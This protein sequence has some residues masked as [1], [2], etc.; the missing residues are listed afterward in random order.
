MKNKIVV[1]SLVLLLLMNIML[2]ITA[3][4]ATSINGY[5]SSYEDAF[6]VN[7]ISS[8][9]EVVIIDEDEDRMIIGDPISQGCVLNADN[10]TK[11]I[12]PDSVI[13]IGN[14]AFEDCTRLSDV[15][16]SNSLKSIG[17][18]A[19]AGTGLTAIDLPDSL[20]SIDEGAFRATKITNVTVPGS[21]GKLVDGRAANERFAAGVFA[22]CKFLQSVT[23]QQG[24]SKVGDF[25]FYGCLS[26][27]S[28]SFANSV[29]TIGNEAFSGCRSLSSLSLPSGLKTLEGKAFAL[30]TSLT[31]VALPASITNYEAPVFYGCSDLEEIQVDALNPIFESVDGVLFSE[32]L[33]T[34]VEY[35]VGAGDEYV[36]PMGTMKIG[37]NAFYGCESLQSIVIPSSVK[38][39]GQGA[40]K[41]CDA[42]DTIYYGGTKAQW[43]ALSSNFASNVDVIFLNE[44]SFSSHVNKVTVPYGT[45]ASITANAK[46]SDL[47]YQWY[48]LEEDELVC[49][50]NGEKYQGV[51]TK[52]LVLDREFNI[53]EN[54]GKE[55]YVCVI[56]NIFGQVI[57][58]PSSVSVIHVDSD[59]KYD[60][61]TD[62]HWYVC[63][64]GADFSSDSHSG[65]WHV[66]KEP[67]YTTKGKEALICDACG[68]TMKTRDV[69]KLIN[70]EKLFDDV[71]KKDW[72]YKNGAIDYVYNKGLFG[73]TGATKFEPKTNM[74]RGMFV[75]VLG[76]LHGVSSAG[77]KT[78]FSDVK[79]SQ[80]YSGYVKWA[81]DNGIVNG[82][83]KTTFSPEADVTREQICAM[84]IRYCNFA[85]VKLQKKNAKVNFIDQSKISSYARSAVT[86]CQQ[87]G[88]VG[89]ED[90]E[91]GYR[92]RPQG[93]ATRAE[94]ATIIMNFGKNYLR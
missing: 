2:P 34:L 37:D 86:T 40:F 92:F 24:I 74:T 65:S 82:T 90:V 52:T 49:I 84:M 45:V 68:Y 80:Y 15:T 78:I 53:C 36:V 81:S 5:Y 77:K 55:Q 91:G 30:C 66:T 23:L 58:K 63:Y 39:I 41:D 9:E 16:L 13:G 35:P 94:V 59:L 47:A 48:L 54:N 3:W 60:Q 88:I 44:P 18:G 69:A 42:L 87:S 83:S 62:G 89:G 7:R 93:N 51:N 12:M 71:N 28:V 11:L 32:D 29:A 75:T 8:D 61:N 25:S 6:I 70:T 43:N 72:F 22:D 17:Y 21:V 1:Y 76:R 46:G 64:C 57:G 14:L 19:F 26:L 56:S 50:E 20:T 73:G 67:T 4:G 33:L 10:C 27:N 38:T 31:N 85:K 79:K